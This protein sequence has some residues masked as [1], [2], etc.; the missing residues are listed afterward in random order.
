MR[1]F[2]PFQA[3]IASLRSELSVAVESNSKVRSEVH[4]LNEE[5]QRYRE[6][7]DITDMAALKASLERKT[8]ELGAAVAREMEKDEAMVAFEDEISREREQ[9]AETLESLETQERQAEEKVA[10][11]EAEIADLKSSNESLKESIE[12]EREER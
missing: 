1:Y 4:K 12:K 9:H 8:D 6:S 5:V 7:T 11:L 3:Q 10:A 2:P